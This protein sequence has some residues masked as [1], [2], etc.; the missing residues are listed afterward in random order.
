MNKK[1]AAKKGSIQPMPKVLVSLRG[2]NGEDNALAVAYC[3]NCSYDPPMVMV[4]IVPSRYSYHMIKESG[5]FVVNIPEKSYIDEFNYLGT[6]SH[7]DCDKLKEKNIAL[8]EAEVINAPM[9]ADCP[10]NVECTVVDSIM[11]GSHDM[12]IGKVERVHA[13]EDILNEDG[14]IDFSKVDFI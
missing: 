10:V 11:T 2:A 3:G 9:L 7:R 4:G 12:F 5:C 14:T 1:I 13:N 6:V 8:A